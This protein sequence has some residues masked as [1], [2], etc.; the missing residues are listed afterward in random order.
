MT[1]RELSGTTAIATGASK[2]FGRA[3]AIALA[4]RGAHVVGVARSEPGLDQLRQELRDRFEFEVADAADP[5]L[6]ERLFA[7][8]RP[9]VVM[10]NAGAAPVVGPLPEQ[11]WETFSTNWHMDVRQVFN[12]AKA[13]LVAPLEPGSVVVIISSAA[14][15]RGS[16]LSGGYAGA[17]AT[18]KFISA[19]AAAEA[20]SRSLGVRFV[21][22]LPMLT[23]ATDLGA[24]GVAAYAQRAG[25]SV[26]AFQDQLAPVL[27]P[28]HLAKTMADLVADD[29]Y[30]EAAYL[31]TGTELSPL[32]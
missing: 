29:S 17:K 16:P 6:P 2:G 13:S 27:T 21:A 10:L 25:A 15:L 18:V 31:L 1:V 24:A 12:F 11:T 5:S 3:T 20:Q 32:T 22:V 26:E 8:H 28:E 7:R 14:A 19:Y 30:S 23:P 9:Q 4:G